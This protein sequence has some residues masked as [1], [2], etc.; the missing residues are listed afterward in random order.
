MTE[1]DNKNQDE[2][3]S[4]KSYEDRVKYVSAIAH[5]LASKKLT[6]KVYKVVKKGIQFIILF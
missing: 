1:K 2:E 6:K 5:P 4:G 3:S